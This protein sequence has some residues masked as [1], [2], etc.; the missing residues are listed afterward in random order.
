MNYDEN[1]N[2][3]GLQE[4]TIWHGG[5]QAHRTKIIGLG[6]FNTV[7]MSRSWTIWYEDMKDTRFHNILL[8]LTR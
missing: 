3:Q 7:T 5:T 4:D 8:K 2:N 1:H 6:T